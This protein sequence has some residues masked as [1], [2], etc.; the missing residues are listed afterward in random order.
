L[1][2]LENDA[3]RQN[4]NKQNKQAKHL[5]VV[6]NDAKNIE[7]SLGNRIRNRNHSHC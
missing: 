1:I 3:M 5:Q 6:N 2:A 7:N 4:K